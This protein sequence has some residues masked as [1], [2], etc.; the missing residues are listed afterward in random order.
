MVEKGAEI[1]FYIEGSLF[2]FR[3][4]ERSGFEL[5]GI[6]VFRSEEDKRRV[7]I[8]KWVNGE[9]SEESVFTFVLGRIVREGL[10]LS[11]EGV[12]MV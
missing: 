4:K 10:E 7:V 12:Y 3:D 1:G 9:Y 5:G 2:R 6:R 8:E 11:F